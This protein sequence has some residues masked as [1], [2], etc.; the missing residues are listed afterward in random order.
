MLL[1]QL[2][3]YIYLDFRLPQKL[4]LATNFRLQHVSN[5][6]ASRSRQRL[7]MP[8]KGHKATRRNPAPRKSQPPGA[9]PEKHESGLAGVKL[10]PPPPPRKSQPPGGGPEKLESEFTREE[11]LWLYRTRDE[12]EHRLYNIRCQVE[13]TYRASI[14]NVEPPQ[15]EW[16]L[17]DGLDNRWYKSAPMYFLGIRHPRQYLVSQGALLMP[18]SDHPRVN[19]LS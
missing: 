3:T 11:L 2:T 12:E 18:L 9:R 7:T 16:R 19:V 13:R 10:P 4:Q 8:R 15:W 5:H 14:D 17:D 6:I 1:P